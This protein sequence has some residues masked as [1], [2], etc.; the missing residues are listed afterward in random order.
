MHMFAMFFHDF[1]ARFI[2]LK[3]RPQAAMV[4]AAA[5]S[6]MY[7]FDASHRN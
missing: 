7:R 5:A 1:S 4:A 2:A 3:V 6:P